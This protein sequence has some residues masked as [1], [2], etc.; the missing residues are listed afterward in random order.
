MIRNIGLG[1]VVLISLN[2]PAFAQQKV[3]TANPKIIYQKGMD[4]LRRGD[5]AGAKTSFEQ[6]VTVA[7]RS[8][9]AHNSLGW[10]LVAPRG[11]RPV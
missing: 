1:L 9:D 3:T 10:V 5:L 8:P 7:P 2:A 6:A 11:S 4:S